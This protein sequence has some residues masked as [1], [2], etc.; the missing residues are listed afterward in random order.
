MKDRIIERIQR[1]AQEAEKFVSEQDC[2]CEDADFDCWY[3][4]SEKQQ[5]DEAIG[6][7]IFKVMDGVER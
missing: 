4:K 5:V 1:I 2:T 7:A 6:Y 3:R